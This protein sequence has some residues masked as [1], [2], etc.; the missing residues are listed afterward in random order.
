[1]PNHRIPHAEGELRTPAVRGVPPLRLG[2]AR[3]A[4]PGRLRARGV[5]SAPELSVDPSPRPS[6]PRRVAPRAPQRGPRGAGKGRLRPRA[7]L[8]IPAERR[9]RPGPGGAARGKAAA[10]QAPGP[11]AR[12]PSA[13]RRILTA[14]RPRAGAARGGAPAPGGCS[15]AGPRGSG[16]EQ[17]TGARRRPRGRCPRPIP[18]VPAPRT[19]AAPAPP[20][21]RG[22]SARPSR[23]RGLPLGPALRRRRAPGA[24]HELPAGVA[25]RNPPACA[26]APSSRAPRPTPFFYSQR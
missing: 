14:E 16:R 6:A 8:C 17:G 5:D 1:M 18:R 19:A 7:L 3:T 4:T 21:A 15:P 22:A 10:R 2:R 11:R 24:R 20:R 25:A 13:F 26:R 23:S 12:S 9:W